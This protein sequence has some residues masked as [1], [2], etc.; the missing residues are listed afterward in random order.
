MFAHTY[1]YASFYYVKKP[2]NSIIYERLKR[3]TAFVS[4]CISANCYYK[5]ITVFGAFPALALMHLYIRVCMYILR[6]HYTIRVCS[7]Y[8]VY[9]LALCITRV[10]NTYYCYIRIRVQSMVNLY[11]SLSNI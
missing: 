10:N 2:N 4:R 7:L 3:F 5:C 1:T 9:T 6:I 8:Y 11:I